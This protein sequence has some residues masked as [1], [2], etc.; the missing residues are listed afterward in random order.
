[1]QHIKQIGSHAFVNSN[2]SRISIPSQIT[3]MGDGAFR[4]CQ[5]LDY[6]EI[7]PDSKLVKIMEAAFYNTKIDEFKIPSSVTSIG[8]YAFSEC[9]S[10]T[11][12]TI[13]SSI[14]SIGDYAFNEKS[15]ESLD[16]PE[17]SKLKILVFD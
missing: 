5:N 16:I 1:M 2:I 17:D 7:K 10:L 4:N 12:I 11:K 8:D 13:P 3:H 14:I 15:I 6:V 9:S